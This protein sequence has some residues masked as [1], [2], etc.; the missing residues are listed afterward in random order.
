[1]FWKKKI[2]S[3][4]SE[5][6]EE[7][8][9]ADLTWLREAFGE[10]HFQS[11]PTKTPTIDFYNRTF[12]GIEDDAQYVLEQ[13]QKMMGLE[14]VK[15]QLDF[16]D[17]GTVHSED[18]SLLTTPSNSIDGSWNSA[19]GIY[20]QDKNGVTL[21]SI[22]RSQLKDPISLIAT[23]AHELSHAILLG[24]G[25]LEENDEYL[26]DLTAIYYGYGMFLGNSSFRFA[27][28]NTISGSVWQ[29]SAQG[30]LPVQV[31]AYAM[32]WLSVERNEELYYAKFLSKSMK[33]Y[34]EQAYKYLQSNRKNHLSEYV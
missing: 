28:R 24:E 23:I 31:I 7:W 26:T 16:F 8:L 29:M 27:Q 20:E 14:N 12:S 11:I 9:N 22:E 18:G 34:V 13:T 2:K 21:I 30:Y 4:V 19:A 25:W 10:E 1:M 17:H 32:A 3:P 5:A 15:I 33:K 6:D